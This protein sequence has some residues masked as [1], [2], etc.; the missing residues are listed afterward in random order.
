MCKSLQKEKRTLLYRGKESW[1]GF[2]KQSPWIIIGWVLPRKEEGVLLP[3]G[4]CKLWRVWELPL[5][6]SQLSWWMFLFISFLVCDVKIKREFPSWLCYYYPTWTTWK[7][8]PPTCWISSIS[9]CP[10]QSTSAAIWERPVSIYTDSW[11]VFGVI[12][13]LGRLW[14]QKSF[15]TSSGTPIHSGPQ[16]D[17]LLIAIFFSSEIA[18]FKTDSY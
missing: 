2:S 3:D 13:D 6:V 1:E 9:R 5:L 14:K 10:L 8:K 15:P 18:A 7:R 16:A 4:L 11:Y 12:Y 17:E